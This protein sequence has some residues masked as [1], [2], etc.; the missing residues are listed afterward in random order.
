MPHRPKKKAYLVIGL[1]YFGRSVARTLTEMGH[2]VVAVDNDPKVVE[3][4]KDVVTHAIQLDATDQDGLRELGIPNFDRCVV[5]RG[6]SLEDSINIVMALNELGARFVVAKAMTDRQ[7]GIL[8][9]L[10]VDQVIFPERDMGVR[11][12]HSLQS[13]RIRDYMDLGVGL[14]IQELVAPPSCHGK[15]LQGLALRRR[16][17]VNVIAIKRG[18]TL[19][20]DLSSEDAIHPGDLLVVAGRASNL[21]AFD[22]AR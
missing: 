7:A 5:G 8:E 1:G 16:F 22:E 15:S 9:K 11:V 19:H 13:P 4:V 18:T 2:E 3:D 20:T 10:G 17:G 6:T 21:E 12:A 14:G